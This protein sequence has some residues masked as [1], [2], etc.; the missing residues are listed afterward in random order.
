MKEEENE[1]YMYD[2]LNR[3]KLV[4]DQVYSNQSFLSA[5]TIRPMKRSGTIWAKKLLMMIMGKTK[6]KMQRIYRHARRQAR[7]VKTGQGRFD[8]SECV[9]FV[10]MDQYSPPFSSCV[11]IL[12]RSRRRRHPAATRP[13]FLRIERLDRNSV[14]RQIRRFL[15]PEPTV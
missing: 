10:S 8:E 2:H 5:W 13:H 6:R 3:K 15:S 12:S 7:C 1:V 14:S 11:R 4:D 9:A